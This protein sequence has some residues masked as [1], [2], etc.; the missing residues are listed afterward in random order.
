MGTIVKR[1]RKDGTIAYMAK[2]ILKRGGKIVHRESETF[3]RKPVARAWLIK[4]E[5]EL[6]IPGEIE[7][8]TLNQHKLKDAINKY[9]EEAE[10]QAGGTKIQVLNTLKEY[11][12]SEMEC[13]KIKS[14]DIVDL[15][16]NLVQRMQPQTVATYLSN[17]SPIFEI[18]APAWGYQLDEGELKKARPVCRRLGYTGKAV[19]RSRRPSLHELDLLIQHFMDRTDYRRGVIPMA[20]VIVF[21]IY[22][23]RRQGEIV[24][25]RWSDLERN[26]GRVLVRDMK[27]PGQKR[28]NNVWCD[29]S[30]QAL[31]VIDSM[32]KVAD[33]IFPYTCESISAA[34]TRSCQFLDINDLRFHDLRHEGISRLFEMGLTIPKVSAT[35]GHR[36]WSSLQRYTHMR[37]DGDKYEGWEWLDKVTDS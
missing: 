5:A 32:P 27:H 23:T 20:K 8:S 31:Q 36:S 33:E 19:S 14:T 6:S 37:Q 15:A 25:I 29:L 22:S 24:R 10:G 26:P 34:F 4:R 35:S 7:R 2:I 12:I 21:A 16:R 28:G 17:L 1:P 13:E 30:E 18:A 3:D 11:P 9:L